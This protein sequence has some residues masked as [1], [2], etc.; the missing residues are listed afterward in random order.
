M[1]LLQDPFLN[2]ILILAAQA[3]GTNHPAWPKALG[4]TT[5]IVSSLPP[6]LGGGE[7]FGRTTQLGEIPQAVYLVDNLQYSLSDIIIHEYTHLVLICAF[8]NGGDPYPVVATIL[9]GTAATVYNLTRPDTRKT[10][11]DN[12]IAFYAAPQYTVF[13]YKMSQIIKDWTNYGLFVRIAEMVPFAVQMVLT[14]RNFNM[15]W[16]AHTNPVNDIPFDQFSNYLQQTLSPVLL[17]LIP[18]ATPWPY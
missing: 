13:R 12:F 18:Q 17:P 9:E 3:H 4:Y 14:F 8:K 6:T 5:N 15:D 16:T 2:M 11:W 10:D 7:V 1:I